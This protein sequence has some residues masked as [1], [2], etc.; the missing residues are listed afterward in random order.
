MITLPSTHAS[1]LA[2]PPLVSGGNPLWGH[3][4]EFLRD[5]L[6]LLLRGHREHGSIFRI[7]LDG[8]C[9]VVLL[10]ADLN[11]LVFT[12]T[13]RRLSIRTAYPWLVRMFDPRFFFF[14]P[15]EEYQLQRQVVLPRFQS[16]ELDGYIEVMETETERFLGSLGD[17]GEIDLTSALAPLV[18]RIAA[19]AFL[20]PDAADETAGLFRDLRRFSDGTDAITPGWLPLPHLVRSRRAGRRLRA[21]ILQLAQRRRAEPT[22][23]SDFLQYLASAS[24]PDGAPV[25]DHVRV[26]LVLLLLWAGHETTTGQLAWSL[27]DLARHPEELRR[28]RQEHHGLTNR[29]TATGINR[30]QHL[31]RCLHESERLHPVSYVMARIAQAPLDIEGWHIRPGSRVM[32]SPAAFHRLP[33]TFPDPDR[34]RP[35]RFTDRSAAQQLIGFGGGMH[36]CLGVRF[37]YLEMAVIVTRLLQRYDLELLD[38]DPQPVRGSSTKWPQPTRVRYR[39]TPE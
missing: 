12:E 10:D 18:V 20:G 11:R 17:E 7:R 22:A 32:V 28:V 3:S 27:I 15:E 25:P 39:R 6:T 23:A 30:L 29:L 33:E 31:N 38:P 36:R 16:R 26:N 19:G 5:P 4:L 21:M 1:A 13:G 34:Y 8:R 35:D 37:A 9:T 24:Y 2:H 14:A